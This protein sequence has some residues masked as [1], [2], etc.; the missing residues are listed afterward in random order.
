MLFHK[1]REAHTREVVNNKLIGIIFLP[2]NYQIKVEIIQF[3][4]NMNDQILVDVILSPF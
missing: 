1:I 3:Q 4:S 2:K